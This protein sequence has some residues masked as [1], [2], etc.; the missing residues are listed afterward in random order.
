[1]TPRGQFSIA[2]DTQFTGPACGQGASPDVRSVKGG[3]TARTGT[4]ERCR[5]C[6]KYAPFTLQFL[7]AV[8]SPEIQTDP[9]APSPARS[10][11]PS[12]RVNCRTV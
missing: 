7:A 3:R 12:R 8:K 10:I 9:L 1:V 2:C 11:Q 4:C 6:T 5:P